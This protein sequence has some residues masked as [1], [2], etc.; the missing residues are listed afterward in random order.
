MSELFF[1]GNKKYNIP[2]EVKDDFLKTYPDAVNGINFRVNQKQYSIPP[3]LENDFL[4]TY[5]NA[6]KY[7]TRDETLSQELRTRKTEDILPQEPN[8]V[9]AQPISVAESAKI[10]T[11]LDPQSEAVER[12]SGLEGVNPRSLV[13]RFNNNVLKEATLGYVDIGLDEP[14]STAETVTDVAGAIGGTILS[15]DT[16][17][18]GS[19]KLLRIAGKKLPRLTTWVNNTIGSNKTAKNIGFNTA[20]DLLTFNV[21][22]QLYNR[23]DIKTL[24]DI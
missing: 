23:P 4:N 19:G 7:Q 18:A 8:L 12:S 17:G 10:D 16:T 2:N 22:G 11:P 20:R 1:V 6:V 15:M 21:H 9:T 14:Q 24:E 5:P 13:D 3:T